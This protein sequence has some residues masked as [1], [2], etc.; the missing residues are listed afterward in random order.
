MDKQAIFNQA[1]KGLASQGFQRSLFKDGGCAYRGAEGRRC[2]LGWCIPDE[3]YDAAFEGQ[4]PHDEGVLR[5]VG[6]Q[7]ASETIDF[8][9]ALQDAHDY[10][11]TPEDMKRDLIDVANRWHLALPAELA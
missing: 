8:L 4:G 5:M 3:R 9:E 2:A 6:A 7:R 1:V 10:P 11:R